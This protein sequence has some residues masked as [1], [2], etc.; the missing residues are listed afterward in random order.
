[1]NNDFD[2][3]I[4]IR[5]EERIYFGN[6]AWEALRRNDYNYDQ[7]MSREEFRMLS[8]LDLG[9]K[10]G[11]AAE[12]CRTLFILPEEYRHPDYR[13]PKPYTRK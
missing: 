10:W 12:N 6:S 4:A 13:N 11:E 2:E 3:I 8:R 1:M 5:I 7:L 9:D